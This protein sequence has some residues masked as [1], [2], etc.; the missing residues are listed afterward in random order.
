MVT[1]SATTLLVLVQLLLLLVG[2]T[3]NKQRSNCHSGRA[4]LDQQ[5]P[6]ARQQRALALR[7]L[8]L[9][10]LSST[11]CRGSL[12]RVTSEGGNGHRENPLAL[13]WH[14]PQASQPAV[15]AGSQLRTER[16]VQAITT[17]AAA[18]TAASETKRVRVVR[19]LQI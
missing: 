10:L 9:L 2:C 19:P 13:E 16:L 5:R 12:R 18:A 15:S 17:A 7:L 6:H 14:V 8:P 1:A 3:A 4:A 11:K